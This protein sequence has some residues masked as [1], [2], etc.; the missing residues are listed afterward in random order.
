MA[1]QTAKMEAKDRMIFSNQLF[2]YFPIKLFL[3]DSTSIPI[4]ITGKPMM[5]IAFTPIVNAMKPGMPG[6]D[7]MIGVTNTKIITHLYIGSFHIYHRTFRDDP[8]LLRK[9]H[10][11]SI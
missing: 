8:Y 10:L 9:R 2:L 11:L 4:A 3:F 7:Q 6:M 1:D 5:F